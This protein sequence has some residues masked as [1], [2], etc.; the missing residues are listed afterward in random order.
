M[1]ALLR[2]HEAPANFKHRIVR[3]MGFG[4]G[5]DPSKAGKKGGGGGAKRLGKE[6]Q[7]RA[8]GKLAVAE[9]RRR[10]EEGN[11]DVV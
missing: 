8:V 5:T 9:K 1:L 2:I 4:S 6:A 10:R 11:E 7:K 3:T